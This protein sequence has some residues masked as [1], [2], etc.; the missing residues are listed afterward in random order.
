MIAAEELSVGVLSARVAAAVGSG[1]STTSRVV[2]RA[3]NM[4]VIKPIGASSAD[5]LW[6]AEAQEPL[7]EMRRAS[8][9]KMGRRAKVTFN[10]L[11]LRARYFAVRLGPEIGGFDGKLFIFERDDLSVAIASVYG[12]ITNMSN[13][14]YDRNGELTSFQISDDA[15]EQA[16]EMVHAIGDPVPVFSDEDAA[17]VRREQ[18]EEE[19]EEKEDRALASS[20]RGRKRKLPQHLAG[21][22]C[23]LQLYYCPKTDTSSPCRLSDLIKSRLC[24]AHCAHARCVARQ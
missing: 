7:I 12:S 16:Y 9:G 11:R 15:F 23:R 13:K 18:E 24:I 1:N 17:A 6:L 21:E 5:M 2:Y 4:L 3:G 8:S 22:L 10:T 14:A 20:S 19:E